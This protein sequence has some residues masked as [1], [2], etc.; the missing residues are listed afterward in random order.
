MKMTNVEEEETLI[1]EQTDPNAS[2]SKVIKSLMSKG[3][4]PMPTALK[5]PNAVGLSSPKMKDPELTPLPVPSAGC[6]STCPMD[7]DRASMAELMYHAGNDYPMVP[8]PGSILSDLSA[9]CH[10]ALGTF[11][12]SVH[13]R[14]ASL[15]VKKLLRN[16]ELHLCRVSPLLDIIVPM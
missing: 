11:I 9:A 1:A 12:K 16:F 5:D 3:E 2:L 6:P 8:V 15:P 4:I 13:E 7:E 14:L 10:S